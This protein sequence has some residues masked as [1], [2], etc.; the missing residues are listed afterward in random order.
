MRTSSIQHITY[1]NQ[2][3]LRGTPL[4][5]Y[6]ALE[7]PLGEVYLAGML[8][9]QSLRDHITHILSSEP[10]LKN[11]IPTC[12]LLRA[13]STPERFM[14]GLLRMLVEGLD[15]FISPIAVETL[16]RCRHVE[17]ESGS[18]GKARPEE[19]CKHLWCSRTEAH[20]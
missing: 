14:L 4:M 1:C 7:R 12:K 9:T 15:G 11:L 5:A 2:A 10:H 19:R 16:V 17:H 3:R 6:W 18:K 13:V 20:Q 8:L